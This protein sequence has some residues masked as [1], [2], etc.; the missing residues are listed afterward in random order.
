[1]IRA[2]LFALLILTPCTLGA[3][4]VPVRSGEH[5]DFSRLVLDFSERQNWEFGRV[6]EGYE[7]RLSNPE[8]E[9]D[10]TTVFR[11][12][13]KTRIQD[14]ADLGDGR[15][16][17]RSECT[18]HGDAFDLRGTQVVVDIKDGPAT[19]SAS[20]FDRE[21]PKLPNP[22]DSAQIAQRPP[23]PS[24]S[25]TSILGISVTMPT[26]FPNGGPDPQ[27]D[28][29]RP[30]LA[31]GGL[32]LAFGDAAAIPLK[33]SAPTSK[34]SVL[35]APD[36]ETVSGETAIL[37]TN[38]QDNRVTPLENALL[39]QIGRAAAQGLLEADIS[40]TEGQI[41]EALDPIPAPASPHPGGIGTPHVPHATPTD[42]V[43]IQTSIDRSMERGRAV[44]AL[45][46][47]GTTCLPDKYFSIS[48]WGKPPSNGA[49]LSLHRASMLGEFDSADSENLQALVRHY[50]YLTFGAEAAALVRRYEADL[51]RP[52]LLVAIA[53]IM[54]HGQARQPD[55]L[56][57]QM[58]CAGAASLWATLAQPSLRRGDEIDRSGVI[59]AFSELPLHLRRHLGPILSA[60]F[61]KIGDTET[62]SVLRDAIARASGSHGSSFD[63]LEAELDLA[64]GNTGP[65]TEQLEEIIDADAA[66]SPEAILKLIETRVSAGL[67]IAD[68]IRE[69]VS[70]LAYEHRGTSMGEA[71]LSAEIR[72]HAY[73]ADFEA[74]F[75]TLNGGQSSGHLAENA[76]ATL[77][78]EAFHL[79]AMN[80]SDP[81]F[82]RFTLSSTA[83]LAQAQSSLRRAVSDR[84]LTLG[85][86]TP[87]REIL[88]TSAMVPELED[89]VL[90]ARAALLEGKPEI[91][92]GYLSGIPTPVAKSLRAESLSML[93]DHD[94]AAS[95]WRDLEEN[96]ARLQEAWRAGDWQQVADMPESPMQ[97]AAK[98]MLGHDPADREASPTVEGLPDNAMSHGSA[99]LEESQAARAALNDLLT[100][101]EKP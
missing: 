56:F 9:F 64:H 83:T 17:I 40:K 87:A 76:A 92:L 3:Q 50:L 37:E 79:L 32:P 84:L 74:A 59:K 72:A 65:A 54:D 55:A 78:E 70:T 16:L 5:V 96:D 58:G 14:V 11:L 82:L 85:F 4:S 15:L 6:P 13:P 53:E 10:L 30:E 12:I 95:I 34:P 27:H 22:Q 97:A 88:D 60:R 80:G 75:Q 100:A 48:H 23:G 69:I 29:D 47:V 45:T 71:L 33:A 39:E 18:C 26:I 66:N 101:L 2:L 77:R 68:R 90:F 61:L 98:L 43:Q 51:E 38:Q 89:R 73:G 42:H 49:D 1:M 8:M 31:R 25:V 86:P 91:A 93:R 44:N 99:L 28:T 7:L 24:A 57:D 63:L 35:A 81:S 19:Q 41:S 21:L 94:A 36:A 62:A 46:Q 52:D 67:P 20:P